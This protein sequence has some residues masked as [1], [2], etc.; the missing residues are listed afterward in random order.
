MFEVHQHLQGVLDD[1]VGGPAQDVRNKPEP[2]GVVFRARVVQP[3]G[4]K[5]P[6][7]HRSPVPA[8]GEAFL[9]R[10][11]FFRSWNTKNARSMVPIQK[12]SGTYLDESINPCDL[13]RKTNRWVLL[14]PVPGADFPSLTP[15]APPRRI[16]IL[17]A[18]RSLV[19]HYLGVVGVA[20]SNPAAPTDRLKATEAFFSQSMRGFEPFLFLQRKE[21]LR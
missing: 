4:W 16:D 20:G 15:P 5:R 21:P 9:S 11:P 12:S 2:A 17:G 10:R 1:G 18:W 14:K 7:P 19:A 13:T 8:E 3:L 6:V